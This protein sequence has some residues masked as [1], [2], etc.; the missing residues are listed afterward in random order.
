MIRPASGFD[1]HLE[2][3]SGAVVFVQAAR[4]DE[5]IVSKRSV[6]LPVRPV[7]RL[8]ESSRIPRLLR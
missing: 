5:C 8:A 4:L 2:H 7:D 1:D 6:A 3:D